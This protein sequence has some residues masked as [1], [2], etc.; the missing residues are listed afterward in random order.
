MEMMCALH[1][2]WAGAL[3]GKSGIHLALA[4]KSFPAEDGRDMVKEG[5][6][7]KGYQRQSFAVEAYFVA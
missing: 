1:C 7:G 4:D 2:T 6:G 3:H 5:V